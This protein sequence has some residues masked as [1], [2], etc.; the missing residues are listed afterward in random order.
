[1]YCRLI[2][3]VYL[4]IIMKEVYNQVCLLSTRLGIGQL[5]YHTKSQV[6]VKDMGVGASARLFSIS[7]SFP[8]L[9]SLVA[10]R[11]FSL[12]TI[13]EPLLSSPKAS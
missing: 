8:L 9:F 3:T 4:L 5:K 11:P 7:D 6:S 12:E 2:L 10:V 13:F 1:M